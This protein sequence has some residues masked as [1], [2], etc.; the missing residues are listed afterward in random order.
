M[1]GTGGALGTVAPPSPARARVEACE[2]RAEASEPE[3]SEVRAAGR[4]GR[5]GSGGAVEAMEQP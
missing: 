1:A 4:S 5:E 3:A 2:G